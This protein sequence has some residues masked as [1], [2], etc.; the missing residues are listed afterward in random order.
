MKWLTLSALS[1]RLYSVMWIF[2]IIRIK[3]EV[4]V[5]FRYF[6]LIFFEPKSTVKEEIICGRNLCGTFFTELLKFVYTSGTNKVDIKNMVWK[7]TFD[8]IV[9]DYALSAQMPACFTCLR[10]FEKL[11][12]TC[13]VNKTK[14]RNSIFRFFWKNAPFWMK[15]GTQLKVPFENVENWDFPF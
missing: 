4:F 14:T 5:W 15:F 3:K 7:S 2:L 13:L 8:V 12:A 11:R 10:A 1:T 9:S 6:L